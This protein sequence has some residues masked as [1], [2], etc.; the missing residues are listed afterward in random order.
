[1]REDLKDLKLYQAPDKEFVNLA[2][3]EN[4]LLD[5]NK[6]LKNEIIDILLNSN[7]N[8]YGDSQHDT[9]V[10]EYARYLKVNTSNILV[11]SGSDSIIPM[12]INV[13]AR[14]KILTLSPDFFRYEQATMVMQRKS[15]QVEIKNGYIDEVIKKVN[16]DKDIEMILLSN[17]NNPLGILHKNEDIIKILDNTNCYVVIDEAYQEFGKESVVDKINEYNKLIVLRTLSKAFALANLRVGFAIAN[18]KLC[19]FL[20]QCLGPFTLSDLNAEISSLIIRNDNIVNYHV[21]EIIKIR[22]KFQSA[23]SKNNINYLSSKAN[24]VYIINENIEELHKMFFDEKIAT[25]LFLPKGMRITL[26]DEKIMSTVEKIIE[27]F[28][29]KYNNSK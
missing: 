6:E 2:N 26:G 22:E 9:L 29:L 27:E 23:L 17:P 5:W 3:N 25:S 13:L 21:D 10:E 7:L 28:S 14:N 16:E 15:I 19:Q 4:L 12:L 24:F 8:K 1:M 18:D 20:K 11:T